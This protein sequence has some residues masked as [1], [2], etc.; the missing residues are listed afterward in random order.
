MN[1]TFYFYCDSVFWKDWSVLHELLLS[2]RISF[3]PKP[4]ANYCISRPQSSN[5]Y[6]YKLIF[7]FVFFI[8]FSFNF[9][10]YMQ[11]Y[12]GYWLLIIDNTA[13]ILKVTTNHFTI[14][15][16]RKEKR[17]LEKVVLFLIDSLY[18]SSDYLLMNGPTFYLL[19]S[20]IKLINCRGTGATRIS[21]RKM[22]A[23]KRQGSSELITEWRNSLEKA[24]YQ[25]FRQ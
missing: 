20:S 23:P 12:I 7:V 10:H 19:C 9:L 22:I 16:L 18:K 6:I 21:A 13:L 17:I 4:F 14:K 2:R 11:N 3:L 8:L 24:N 15:Y 5:V 1:C 25:S